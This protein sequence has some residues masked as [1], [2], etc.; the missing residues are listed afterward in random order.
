MFALDCITHTFYLYLIFNT[1]VSNALSEPS[2]DRH[3]V[4]IIGH[5]SP[6]WSVLPHIYLRY[7]LECT[8]ILFG[9]FNI[10]QPINPQSYNF[11][12]RALVIMLSV[13]HDDTG[14]ILRKPNDIYYFINLETAHLIG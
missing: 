7:M 14:M 2:T 5:S 12:V 4:I 13:S 3:H 10:K 8:C 6:S 1:P 11:P 9:F